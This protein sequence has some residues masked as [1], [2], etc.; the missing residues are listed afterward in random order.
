LLLLPGF[1]FSDIQGCV[2]P[3]EMG[4]SFG[5]EDAELKHRLN[6]FKDALISEH[7]LPAITQARWERHR[8][9]FIKTIRE[10]AEK[11]ATTEESE[12]HIE[13]DYTP[14]VGQYDVGNI[15]VEPAFLL[16]YAAAGNGQIMKVQTLGS[17]TQVSASG[18][19][20]MADMSQRESAR[21]VEA[22]DLLIT[23]GWVK[24]VGHKGQIFELTGTGY[25]KADWLKEGM[26]INTDNE[27]LEELKG[28]E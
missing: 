5:M 8:D 28:F 21:W 2:D 13:D 11:K 20:F 15:P 27:P 9:K 24:A 23:W 1:G 6:E 22:L 26:Q 3:R 10:I 18:K 16:V 17:P 14:I 7:H 25:K 4:I 12:D 19:E